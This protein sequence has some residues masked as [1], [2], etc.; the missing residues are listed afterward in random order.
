MKFWYDVIESHCIDIDFQEVYNYICDH[1]PNMNNHYDIYLEFIDYCSHY[2]YELY[3][4]KDFVKED[5]DHAIAEL[6]DS[7]ENWLEETFGRNWDEV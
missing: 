1:A 5:N 3:K 4:L 7:W 2:L 6:I